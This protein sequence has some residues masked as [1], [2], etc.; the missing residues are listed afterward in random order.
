MTD[1]VFC[2]LRQTAIDFF[3]RGGR[4]LARRPT[5]AERASPTANVGELHR[6]LLFVQATGDYIER[7]LAFADVFEAVHVGMID[8]YGDDDGRRRWD[9]L[10]QR[11]GTRHARR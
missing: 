10:W 9:V 7:D 8:E 1:V 6:R 3:E 4:N 11:R 5:R 2:R